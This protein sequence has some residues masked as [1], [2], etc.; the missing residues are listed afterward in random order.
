MDKLEL[1]ALV[2]KRL[3]IREIAKQTGRSY[4]SV[5]YWL[6]KLGLQ[7]K[8][9]RGPGTAKKRCCSKCGETRPK[10]F[11]GHKRSICGK[12]HNDYCKT[13]GRYVRDRIVAYLGG[14]CRLCRFDKYQVAL[15]VHHCDPNKKDPAFDHKRGWSWSRIE[16]ELKRGCVLLCKNCHS[17]VH[18]GEIVLEL[19]DQLRGVA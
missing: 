1:L 18:S 2:Q 10:L 5:R 15:D 19:E 8:P 3:G 4:T 6:N 17:A 9:L 7:T 16:R 14:C 11:Y 13:K 12:C